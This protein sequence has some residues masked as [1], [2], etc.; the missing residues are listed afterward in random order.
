MTDK[1]G[2]KEK[3][4]RFKR[5]Q[6]GNP[7]G[8]PRG[9]KN[10]AL[11]ALDRIGES[12]AQGLLQTVITKALD[13]DMMAARILLDRAWPARRG[14]PVVFDA[15]RVETAADVVRALGHIL[16]ATASG[17]LTIEEAAGLAA[18]I[19]TQRKAIETTELDARLSELER[20]QNDT[21]NQN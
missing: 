17:Q 11:V 1:T 3:P 21:R 4:W 14:R 20:R 19:E 10:A 5:G 13:G 6:S 7:S 9:S 8:R 18:I 15:P 12:A 2:P 16:D